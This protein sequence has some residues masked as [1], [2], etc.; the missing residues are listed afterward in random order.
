MSFLSSVDSI[1]FTFKPKQ[2]HVFAAYLTL[3]CAH[4]NEI[5]D[6]SSKPS[7]SFTA[8]KHAPFTINELL[9]VFNKLGIEYTSMQASSTVL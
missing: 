3:A 2:C 6:E 7:H 4:C 8:S 9:T 5:F 1:C